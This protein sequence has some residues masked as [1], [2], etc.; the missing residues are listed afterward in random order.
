MKTLSVLLSAAL[1]LLASA[2]FAQA[3]K[4]QMEEMMCRRPIPASR[5]TFATNIPS[6]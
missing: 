5:F 1:T 6:A 3:P 4:I 2:A